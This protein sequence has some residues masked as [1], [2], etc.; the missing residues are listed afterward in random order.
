MDWKKSRERMVEGQLVPRG[1]N[2]PLILEAFKKVERHKFVLSEFLEIAYADHPLPIGSSQTI[3]QP[4]MVALMTEA[5]RLT[6]K[7]KV[8]EVGTGSGYQAAILAELASKV[9]S[10]ERIPALAERASKTLKELG[11]KNIE[12]KVG[13]GSLGWEENAPYDAVIITA[14]CPG[15]PKTLIEQLADRGRL[16]APIGGPFGQILTI[17]EKK[18]NTVTALEICGCVFVPLIGKEGWE[19]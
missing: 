12:I 2:D 1:I 5:L 10:I 18:G 13:D 11:Y 15:K 19:R 14:S 16:I 6:G 17:F 8:L 4:Y 7:E 3:S 9:Y